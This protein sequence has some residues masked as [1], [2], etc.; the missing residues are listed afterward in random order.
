MTTVQG[1][2]NL[3]DKIRDVFVDNIRVL[4]QRTTYAQEM[5]KEMPNIKKYTLRDNTNVGNLQNAATS[6]RIIDAFPEID[7]VL[8]LIAVTTLSGGQKIMGMGSQIVRDYMQVASLTST[9]VQP[10]VVV[11][12]M[13]FIVSID[14]IVNTALFDPL[15]FANIGSATASEVA[16]AIQMQIPQL[17]CED[18]GAGHVM[19]SVKDDNND[20]SMV[21][22]SGSANS[23]LGFLQGASDSSQNYAL[24]RDLAY[25]ETLTSVLD[26][27]AYSKDVRDELMDLVT[28]YF[29]FYMAEEAMPY[30][31]FTEDSAAG[32]LQIMFKTYSKS[33]EAETPLE[34]NS[35]YNK[36]YTQTMTLNIIARQFVRRSVARVGQIVQPVVQVA[37]P[38]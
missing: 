12:G 25:T 11:S 10:F 15:F 6:V 30:E 8:P 5:L 4:F 2:G 34:G 19:L 20:H 1:F 14:G 22:G 29:G 33:S 13:S 7:K 17:V 35:P 37:Q 36:I 31:W 38:I 32:A 18:N 21:I 26:V 3:D 9:N 23:I 16:A 28:S 27:V 24:V